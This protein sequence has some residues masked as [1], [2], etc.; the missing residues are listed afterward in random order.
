MPR[1]LIAEDD[2][3]LA[4]GMAQALRDAGHVAEPVADGAKALLRLGEREYDLLVLD[5]DLPRIPGERVLDALA[6]SGDDIP[7][8][9]VT[10]HDGCAELTARP[11]HRKSACLRKPFALVEFEARVRMLVRT[12]APGAPETLRCGRLALEPA[13]RRVTCDGAGVELSEREF[14]LLRVLVTEP[15]HLAARER[16]AAAYAGRDAALGD[17]AI[18]VYVHRLRRKL[19]PHGWRISTVRGLGYCLHDDTGSKVAN[20]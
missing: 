19:E 13:L 16:I 7:V 9:V 3:M 17:N 4:E 11:N 18:D 15:G 12:D 2:P 6:R 5:L 8:L 14:E 20:P 1:I 10:A